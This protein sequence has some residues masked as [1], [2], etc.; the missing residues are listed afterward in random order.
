VLQEQQTVSVAKAGII[1]T[2]NARTSVLA[3]ANPIH[4]KFN[5]NM[6]IVENIN[7]VPSLLSRLVLLLLMALP[8]K[9]DGHQRFDLVYVMLDKC[10]EAHDTRLARHIVSLY[11]DGYQPPE[12]HTIVV[13]C[14]CCVMVT[15]GDSACGIGH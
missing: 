4:S 14:I 11:I 15:N 12:N 7:I 6:S 5:E 1:T 10:T 8:Q 9:S 13:S 3:A 2:L